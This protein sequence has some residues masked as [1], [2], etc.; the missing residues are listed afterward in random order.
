MD[1]P[2]LEE[3]IQKK[4]IQCHH[5]IPQGNHY[6][7]PCSFHLCSCCS[8]WPTLSEGS[9]VESHHCRQT[10]NKLPRHQ[11]LC[12]TLIKFTLQRAGCDPEMVWELY[13]ACR[14]AGSQKYPEY[15][16]FFL[17]NEP[18]FWKSSN[19]QNACR[20]SDALTGDERRRMINPGSP[21]INPLPDELFSVEVTFS[22]Y[23]N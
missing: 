7:V 9:S 4:L 23:M 15:N 3:D 8:S 12:N 2:R 1:D 21:F 6:T 20:Y 13:H 14:K 11:L 16:I 10:D 19:S 5:K 17:E 18:F 22:L